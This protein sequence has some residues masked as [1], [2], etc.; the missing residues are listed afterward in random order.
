M[1]NFSSPIIKSIMMEKYKEN[2]QL[3]MH[4]NVAL[5]LNYVYKGED[6]LEEQCKM[7]S[8]IEEFTNVQL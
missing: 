5:L 2:E 6:N 4:K 1:I 7:K 3:E 8:S